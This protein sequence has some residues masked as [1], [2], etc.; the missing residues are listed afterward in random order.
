MSEDACPNC[1]KLEAQLAKVLADLQE[2]KA[3]LAL[4]STTSHQPPSQDKSWTPKSERQKSGRTSGA[5]PGHP[6]KTLKM[7]EHPDE[8]V[9]LPV[10]G[11]CGCGHAWD[12]VTV[13]DELA[14]QVLDLPEIRLH[15]VEYR[16]QVK[17]CPTCHCREQA[18][19]PAQVPGHVQYG[20]RIHGLAVLLNAVH[21][22]PLK[23]TSNI[24]EAVCGAKLSDGT[25][26]LSLQVTAGRLTTFET[27][28]KAALLEQPVLH[29]DETGSKVNGKLAW[30]HVVSCEQLTLYG[31]HEQ[32]GYA[33]LKDMDVLPRFKG[34]VIHDA[35]ITYFQL[36]AQHALCNAH[37][38]REWRHLAEGHGQLWAGELR[39][40]MQLVYHENKMGT[41]TPEGKADFLERFDTFV[42]AGLDTNPAVESVAGNRG[43]V[44][45]TK[46]R[47]LALRCQRYREAI[48]R[49][50]HDAQVPFDNNQAERD[51]R[52]ACVKRKVS[53]GFRSVECG[54]NFCRIRSYTSTLHKQGVNIYPGLV[55][56]F[57]GDT[58][59]PDFSY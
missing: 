27:E 50:L 34:T 39:R 35:W 55:S 12:T 37:L 16:A 32:R 1:K 53:G 46:G 20:P 45:Q 59:M 25:I 57:R 9:T 36:P 11:H 58:L 10:T 29:A 15:V 43:R 14:R 6:G 52:M 42:Q 22:V 28:L 54:V 2:V 21:F 51:I 3:R 41:L 47:N 4:N 48:L 26:S 40:A 23:R 33:A 49:F 44:K 17:I 30:M 8:V 7:V 13:R 18:T 5:Q 38:L 56:V 24:L 19:F 31:H